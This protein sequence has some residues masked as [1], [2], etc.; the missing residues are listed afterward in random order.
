MDKDGQE[1]PKTQLPEA[2]PLRELKIMFTYKKKLQPR[3]TSCFFRIVVYWKDSVVSSSDGHQ[4][5]DGI[6][7]VG[8]ADPFFHR[9]IF[10]SSVRYWIASAT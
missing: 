9:I 2:S 5:I 8:F 4:L 3:I 10:L 6:Y 1:K 7:P